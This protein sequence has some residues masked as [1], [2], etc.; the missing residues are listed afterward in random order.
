MRQ[1]VGGHILRSIW[2]VLEG[3][4]LV[5]VSNSMPCG[6][7]GRSGCAISLRK[8]NGLRFKLETN[9]VFKTKLSLGPAS[10][11]TKRTPCTNRPVIC[12]LC[13]YDRKTKNYPAVWTYN[14][15]AHFAD[16]HKSYTLQDVRLPAEF[17]ESLEISQFE[18]RELRIPEGLL[19]P[20]SIAPLEEGAGGSPSIAIHSQV[21]TAEHSGGKRKRAQ[22]QLTRSMRSRN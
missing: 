2:G 3:D 8:T 5:Q 4:L 17:K 11:S 14:M 1:H 15:A 18:R 6:F 13:V 21:D 16:Q 20:A 19:P 12:C 10:N 9:C 7:C 22:S